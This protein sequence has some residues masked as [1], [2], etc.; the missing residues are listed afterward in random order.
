MISL[1]SVSAFA[2]DPDG[3]RD[4]ATDAQ[5]NRRQKISAGG[6][7]LLLNRYLVWCKC[8]PKILPRGFSPAGD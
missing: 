3:Y 4:L 2:F 5:E 1:P 6:L 7:L 8:E